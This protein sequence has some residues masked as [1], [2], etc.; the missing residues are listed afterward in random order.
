MFEKTESQEASKY[1]KFWIML[2]AIGVVL[3]ISGLYTNNKLAQSSG[4]AMA[5]SFETL[6]R[7]LAA[8]K[9]RYDFLGTT[10]GIP[11]ILLK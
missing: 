6:N 7:I 3:F 5:I 10:T 2:I 1:P 8:R 9:S 4:L 11:R